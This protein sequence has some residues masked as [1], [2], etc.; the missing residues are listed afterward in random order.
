[1]P[2]VQD[3]FLQLI[4]FEGEDLYNAQQALL[5]LFWKEEFSL[6]MPTFTYMPGKPELN[7]GRGVF[8]GIKK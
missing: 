7:Y 5:K 3:H 2:Q 6:D 4:G 1:M 8:A